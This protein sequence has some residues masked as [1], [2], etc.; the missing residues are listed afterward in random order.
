MFRASSPVTASAFRNRTREIEALKSAFDALASGTPRW[1]A[2]LGPRK[3]GKTSLLLEAAQRSSSTRVAVL[4]TL[5]RSP[6]TLDFFRWLAVRALDALA[7]DDAGG[8]LARRVHEPAAFRALLH[9][10]NRVS[11]L[12]APLRNDLAALPDTKADRDSVARWLQLPEELASAF[13]QPLVVAIDEVQ[14]LATL[15]S[16]HFDPFPMMRAAWQRHEHVAYIISGSAPSML[17]ELVTARHSPF[18]MHFQLMEL[19]PFARSDALDLLL[20]G[21]PPDRRIPRATAN[22][23]ADVVGGHPFYLQLVGEALVSTDPPYDDEALK[24]VLQSLLFSRTGRLS[25]YFET[26]FTRIVGRAA[27][28]A[29]TLGAV[30]QHGPARMTD[31]AHAIGA[32]TASTARYLE[33]LG[34]A[35]VRDENALY[36]MADSLFGTWVRWRNPGGS[37][38]PMTVI[39]DEAEIAVAGELSSLGFDLVYQSRAS[40]GAFDLLATRGG[41]QLGLQVKRTALPIRFGKTEWK[42]M[43]AD[44]QRFGWSWAIA[45][46]DPSG[47]VRI[48][49]PAKAQVGREVRLGESAAIDNLLK[50]ID[51]H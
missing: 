3:I 8:S 45:S 39:G 47:T 2:L 10:S 13:K 29:A 23:I 37:V 4:D 36:R 11:S 21:G 6:L 22:R 30:A 20:D 42:R 31:I 34:D 15:E 40:R 33:R 18:F 17:R 12:P 14:E 5:E 26:E 1:I 51:R 38:V 46:V 35:I 16:K 41:D 43:Q 7:A 32:S 28:L 19:D 27:T 49:D 50:W 24:P 44:A 48:L 9:A 25:L